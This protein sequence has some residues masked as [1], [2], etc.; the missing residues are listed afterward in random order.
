M[1]EPDY[2]ECMRITPEMLKSIHIQAV[3]KY[4]SR[5]DGTLSE[6]CGPPSRENK[7]SLLLKL[8]QG[9]NE[10]LVHGGIDTAVDKLQAVYDGIPASKEIVREHAHLVLLEAKRCQRYVHSME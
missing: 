4:L 6:E 10:L 7:R 1:A 3:G 8:M 5:E 9:E 2:L